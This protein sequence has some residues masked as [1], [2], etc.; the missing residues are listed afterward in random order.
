MVLGD[1]P[2][3]LAMQDFHLIINCIS[4]T[5]D[6][7]C[8][9]KGASMGM[10]GVKLG[11]TSTVQLIS[12]DDQLRGAT[13]SAFDITLVKS[14][15]LKI[16]LNGDSSSRATV[17]PDKQSQFCAPNGKEKDPWKTQLQ[18]SNIIQD[19]QS[20]RVFKGSLFHFSCSF[21]QE[22]VSFLPLAGSDNMDFF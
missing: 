20:S 15:D 12:P 16:N 14:K 21:P 2:L 3:S 1:N 7:V 5:A 18:T 4:Q 11:K 9:S 13:N 19:V 10:D 22:R 17:R 6:P 8:S